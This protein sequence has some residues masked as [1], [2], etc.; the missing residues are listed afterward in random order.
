MFRFTSL[1]SLIALTILALNSTVLAAPTGLYVAG[2]PQNRVDHFDF[3]GNLI[4]SFSGPGGPEEPGVGGVV[5]GPDDVLY[6]NS[7]DDKGIYRYDPNDTADPVSSIGSF[8]TTSGGNQ[9]IAVGFRNCSDIG[10]FE[11]LVTYWGDGSV[12]RYDTEGNTLGAF[13]TGWPA[14]GPEAIRE[15]NGKV[16]IAG[17]NDGTIRVYEGPGPHAYGA[18]AVSYT[19]LTL[20]T[21]REV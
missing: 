12:T 5:I 10:N 20:P 18:D 15:N 21:N 11:L 16:Y 19:H 7:Y 3:E 9:S 2:Y 8:T 14:G 4:R 1:A 13:V 6:T 17:R